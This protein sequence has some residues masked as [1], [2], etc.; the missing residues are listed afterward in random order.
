MN[1]Y[2]FNIQ[3][4]HSALHYSKV[5]KFVIKCF[6][7]EQCE[8]C[9]WSAD[10]GLDEQ[11]SVLKMNEESEIQKKKNKSPPLPMRLCY[12]THTTITIFILIFV[13]SVAFST[14]F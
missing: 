2:I 8:Q 9:E 13:V 14:K 4:S 12:T 5:F 6:Q 3:Y 10:D 7:C 1:I 11:F